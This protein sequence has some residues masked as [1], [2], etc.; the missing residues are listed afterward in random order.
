M[1]P[2][3]GLSH[4]LSA[5]ADIRNPDRGMMQKLLALWPGP[6]SE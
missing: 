3:S 6:S 2:E 1:I 4:G 5:R